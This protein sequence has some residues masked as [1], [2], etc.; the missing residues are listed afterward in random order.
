MTFLEFLKGEITKFTNLDMFLLQSA[1]DW[2]K[3][4]KLMGDLV[5]S[6]WTS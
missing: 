5:S 2:R 1:P 3:L 4:Q 6:L